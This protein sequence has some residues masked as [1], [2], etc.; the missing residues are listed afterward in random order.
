MFNIMFKKWKFFWGGNRN[1][2]FQ[3]NEYESNCQLVS[4]WSVRLNE[5][6]FYDTMGILTVMF[7]AQISQGS[8]L[9]VFILFYYMISGWNSRTSFTQATATSSLLF[10]SK[11][12][13][14]ILIDTSHKSGWLLLGSK[15]RLGVV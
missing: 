1:L 15:N 3:D 9:A 5:G 14:Y 8:D 6:A 13:L 11:T 10:P 12:F 4:T 7:D 2:S